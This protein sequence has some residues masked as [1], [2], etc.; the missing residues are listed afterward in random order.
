MAILTMSAS[1]GFN[2][3]LVRLRQIGHSWGSRP[4]RSFNPTLVR[5]RQKDRNYYRE[6][7]RGFNPTLV[8]LRPSWSPSRISGEVFVS[9]PRW[10][11]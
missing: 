11:D 1:F 4:N 10:F 9:I 8:R 6:Q 2:P 3:T 7:N 5:L